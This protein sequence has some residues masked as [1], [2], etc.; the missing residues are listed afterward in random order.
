M[1][2]TVLRIGNIENSNYC[3]DGAVLL[4]TGSQRSFVTESVRKK[5]KLPAL[6][7][8]IMIV[9]VFGQSDNKV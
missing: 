3:T 1:Q 8:E 7:K 4:D 9:Q 5:L 2:S 6:R